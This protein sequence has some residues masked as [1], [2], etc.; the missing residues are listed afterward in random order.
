MQISRLL[1]FPGQRSQIAISLH[2]TEIFILEIM[3]KIIQAHLSVVQFKYRTIEFRLRF[4]D[5]SQCNDQY[6]I[7][8]NVLCRH[9]SFKK[10]LI[11]ALNCLPA[12]CMAQTVYIIYCR[13]KI[14]IAHTMTA[15]PR[16]VMKQQNTFVCM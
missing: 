9:L 8:K 2:F 11:L 6:L 14:R 12:A 10:N 16:V 5:I 4:S 13:C 7:K 1:L 15:H 3:M